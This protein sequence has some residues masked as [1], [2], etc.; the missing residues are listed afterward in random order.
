[1]GVGGM[2]IPI[3][4]ARNCLEGSEVPALIVD[5]QV[6]AEAVA[7]VVVEDLLGEAGAEV[8]NRAGNKAASGAEVRTGWVSMNDMLHTDI[9]QL[10]GLMMPVQLLVRLGRIC[11]AQKI[12]PGL[13]L[14]MIQGILTMTTRRVFQIT[15]WRKRKK[16]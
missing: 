13:L 11:H 16:E 5:M 14:G 1:M 6:E 9:H 10:Q 8:M 2:I 15:L 3:R 12:N 7:A 4:L